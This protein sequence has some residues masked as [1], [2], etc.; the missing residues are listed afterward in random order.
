MTAATGKADDQ[1]PCSVDAV[2]ASA[3]EDKC[4]NR[5]RRLLRALARG[6]QRRRGGH[7]QRRAPRVGPAVD[8]SGCRESVHGVRGVSGDEGIHT[9]CC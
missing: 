2:Q 1:S 8:A 5:T 9:E 3:F 6:F 4:I 7:V